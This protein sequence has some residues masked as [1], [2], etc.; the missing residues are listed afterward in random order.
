MVMR[1]EPKLSSVISTSACVVVFHVFAIKV[2]VLLIWTEPDAAV[3]VN[4][5]LKRVWPGVT[6]MP[7]STK[8][9]PVYKTLKVLGLSAGSKVMAAVFPAK[10]SVASAKILL[11]GGGNM[12][13]WSGE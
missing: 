11:G 9:A 3:R 5:N 10:A 8:F 2:P 1:P 13:I 6:L 4:C 12:V 7:G